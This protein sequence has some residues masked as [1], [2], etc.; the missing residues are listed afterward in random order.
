MF[1][2]TIGLFHFTFN[3]AQINKVMFCTKTVRFEMEIDN[4]KKII[5]KTTIFKYNY[6]ISRS[7][8]EQ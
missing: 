2:S 4:L 1:E 8:Q 3:Q 6:Y 5:S 7:L